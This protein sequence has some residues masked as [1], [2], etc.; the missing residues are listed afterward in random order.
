MKGGTLLPGSQLIKNSF[1]NDMNK[2]MPKIRKLSCS[3]RTTTI[4]NISN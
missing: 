2:Q 4:H 1:G 3:E